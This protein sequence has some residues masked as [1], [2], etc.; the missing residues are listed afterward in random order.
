MA[1]LHVP[2]TEIIAQL[3]E[4]ALAAIADPGSDYDEDQTAAWLKNFPQ[5]D[6]WNER[7]SLQEIV[8]AV[9]HEGGEPV[10]FMSLNTDGLIDFA[11]IH[12]SYQRLGHFRRLVEEIEARARILQVPSLESRASR[13][14]VGPFLACGFEVISGELVQLDAVELE[15]FHVRKSLVDGFKERA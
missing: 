12:P 6:D 3:R 7:I 9:D 5:K 10:G 2:E 13:N 15:R 8:V 14:A 4:I 11:F 1:Y